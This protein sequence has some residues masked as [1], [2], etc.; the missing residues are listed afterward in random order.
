MRDLQRK[1]RKREG[2]FSRHRS[3]LLDCFRE[4]SGRWAAS[5]C[6]MLGEKGVVR[7]PGLI[8][9]RSADAVARLPWMLDACTVTGFTHHS[10][11]ER[12][13]RRLIPALEDE[14]G[15]RRSMAPRWCIAHTRGWGGRTSRRNKLCLEIPRDNGLLGDGVSDGI[16][17]LRQMGDHVS[18]QKLLY[19]HRHS[20]LIQVF[21]FFLKNI[22]L[23]SY[24]RS[25]WYHKPFWVDIGI[26]PSW[27][28]GELEEHDELLEEFR[29]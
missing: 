2:E 21:L 5:E 8:E 15:H 13:D 20:T 24:G 19:I 29:K 9:A 27:E 26:N 12:Q 18:Q 25:H 23:I 6:A 1:Y 10:E 16:T 3:V 22:F 17:E 28:L 11:R 7:E 14:S 4:S